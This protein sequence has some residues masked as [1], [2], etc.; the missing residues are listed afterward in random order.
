MNQK[1]SPES[2][3]L[4]ISFTGKGTMLGWDVGGLKA[5]EESLTLSHRP[6]MFSGNSSGAILVTHFACR[7][8]NLATLKSSVDLVRSF[9]RSLV[10]EDTNSKMLAVFRNEDPSYPH[11]NMK[12]LIDNVTDG[13]NPAVAFPLAIV[14]ANNE[15]LELREKRPGIKLKGKRIQEGANSVVVAGQLLGKAC[16]YFANAAMID[17]LKGIAYEERQCDIRLVESTDDLKMAV[18]A[19]VSEPTYFPPVPETNMAK[20]LDPVTTESRWYNGGYIMSV[21]AQDIK[22]A[23]PG[24]RALG[25]GRKPFPSPINLLMRQWLMVD[26]NKNMATNKWW[27]DL[28]LLPNK[29]EWENLNRKSVT[30]DE[31]IEMGYRKGLQCVETPDQCLD[32]DIVKPLFANYPGTTNQVPVRQ[33][34]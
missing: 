16:T 20:V 23:V 1:G 14:A 29:N 31:A 2:S 3:S 8:F 24:A 21:V 19:S 11:S 13:C 15:L 7:G 22:R 10:N 6:L 32:T 9:D 12:P 17:I 34:L 25:T 5:M 33:G 27:L 4:L 26:V 28:E 18:Y 30:H